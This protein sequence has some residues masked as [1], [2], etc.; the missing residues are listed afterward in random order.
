VPNKKENKP[1]QTVKAGALICPT[2]CVELFEIEVDFE[3]DGEILRDIKILRCPVCQEEQ[4]S[5]QQQEAVAKQLRS[6]T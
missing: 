3:L 5:P 4:F 1:S 6:K 2:C